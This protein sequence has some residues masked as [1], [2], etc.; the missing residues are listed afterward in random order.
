[1]RFAPH[2]DDEVREMLAACGLDSLDDLFAHVPEELRV[3]GELDLPEGISEMELI[4]ELRRLAGRNRHADDLICFAGGGAYDHYVPAVVWALAGRSE[5][6]TSYTPYQPE[7][8]QGVLQALFEYQSMICEL[9]GL[10]VSNAS[11]YDGPTSLVEAAHM[12]RAAT[13]RS[14]LLLAP[15][16]DPRY[17]ETLRTYGAG[18]HFELEDLAEEDGLV[19]VPERLPDGVAAVVVQHPNALGLL[20]PVRELFALARAAGAR[21]VQ[22]FDP[23]SLGRT[24]PAG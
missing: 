11:Q 1:M 21:A 13:G 9:T 8:S 2:T 16:L 18:E 5:L 12:A 3:D 10:E 24:G 23:L 20:E 19:R 14:R 7:L 15:G 17:R 22:V 6:Y 4:G